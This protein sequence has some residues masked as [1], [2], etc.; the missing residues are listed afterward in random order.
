MTRVTPNPE[1]DTLQLVNW[2]QQYLQN[3]E[4]IDRHCEIVATTVECATKIREIIQDLMTRVGA[5]GTESLRDNIAAMEDRL[6]HKHG[7][8]ISDTRCRE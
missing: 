7:I 2:Q 5:H 1:M 8:V 3:L 4:C 6:K